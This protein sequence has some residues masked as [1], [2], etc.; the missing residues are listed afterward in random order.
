MTQLFEQFLNWCWIHK[1]WFVLGVMIGSAS[2]WLY[3]LRFKY[4]K[5]KFSRMERQFNTV[6]PHEEK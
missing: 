1:W 4:M 3:P 2:V 6:L 5:W